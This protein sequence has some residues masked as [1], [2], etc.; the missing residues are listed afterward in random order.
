[1]RAIVLLFLTYS[2]AFGQTLMIGQA[3]SI[4]STIPQ[5]GGGGGGGPTGNPLLTGQ[6]LVTTESDYTGGLGMEITV[7]SNT[8]VAVTAIGRWCYSGNS[9]SH[10]LSIYRDD[11]TLLTNV[12][13]N[14][15]GLAS[16]QYQYVTLSPAVTLGFSSRFFIMSAETTG[17]DVWGAALSVTANSGIGTVY[18]AAYYDG[19]CHDSGNGADHC[20]V[21]VNL[22]TQ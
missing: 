1:M 15:S 11:S 10:V 7:N 16:G 21:P 3:L 12:T 4:G 2:V 19:T 17:G 5:G 14:L 9:G 13:I 22:L 18:D 20:H 6:T 8:N